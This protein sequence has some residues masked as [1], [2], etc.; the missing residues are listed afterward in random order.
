MGLWLIYTIEYSESDHNHHMWHQ[1]LGHKRPC[2][3]IFSVETLAFGTLSHHVRSWLSE[4]GVLWKAQN[5]RKTPWSTL[6]DSHSWAHPPVSPGTSYMS[7]EADSSSQPFEPPF[8][9]FSLPSW[10]HRLV[11]QKQAIPVLSCPNSWPE[12][13][14]ALKELENK[15]QTGRNICKKYIW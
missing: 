4:S 15:T 7:G 14:M 13:S 11:D 3:S 6:I 12:E 2:N 10:G 9:L 5:N 1:R 8:S